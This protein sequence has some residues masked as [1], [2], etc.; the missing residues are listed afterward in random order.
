MDARWFVPWPPFYI[1]F[2]G[3]EE[4]NL[5]FQ[6]SQLFSERAQVWFIEFRLLVDLKGDISKALIK[7]MANIDKVRAHTTSSNQAASS[8][9][10]CLA[11]WKFLCDFCVLFCR[12]GYDHNHPF[13]WLLSIPFIH[14]SNVQL[15][16][17]PHIPPGFLKW[18]IIWVKV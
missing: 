13:R 15:A 9:A 11:V 8:C 16:S 2:I 10:W 18:L 6:N 14:L 7:N 1:V 17:N 3:S 12:A 4:I 5:C